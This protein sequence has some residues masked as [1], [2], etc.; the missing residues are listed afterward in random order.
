MKKLF[1]IIFSTIVLPLSAQK[2]KPKKEVDPLAGIEKELNQILKD[3]K[4]A[5]FAVAV[6][7]KDSVIYAQGFGYRDYENKLPVTPNTLFAIGS[8]TKAFTT[9]L[10][11]LMKEEDKLEYDK[12][13]K[14]Y[15][16]DLKFYS[17]DLTRNVTVRDAIVH[18]TGLPRHDF[19]WYLFSTDSREELMKRITYMEPTAP[20]RQ[21]WQYNNF[22]YLLQGMIAEKQYGK[23]WEEVVREKLLL[24]LNMKRSNTSISSYSEDKDAAIGYVLKNDS[25][26]TKT[27]Y[28]NINAMGPAGS[29]NSSVLEMAN[30]LKVW[31]NK[32]KFNG[33][34]VLPEAYI[35]EAI[36]SQ[37][38]VSPGFPGAASPDLHMSNYGF[39]WSLSSYR[40]HYRVDHG[41]NIDGFSANTAFYPS[42]SLG[43]VVLTNQN[44][45]ALNNVVR[46]TLADRLLGLK[47]IDW[48]ERI[49][50]A[51]AESKSGVTGE[52]NQKKGTQPSHPLKDYEGLYTNKGYGTFEVKYQNDSLI[53]IFPI[54][55]MWLRHYHYDV[56]QAVG[57]RKDGRVDTTEVSSVLVPFYMSEVGDIVSAKLKF[58]PELEAF[59]FDRKVKPKELSKE[60]LF[61]FEGE[62]EM[63]PGAIAKV[64]VKNDQLHVF[65]K[66]QPEYE[67]LP[68]GHQEFEIKTLKGFTLA[69][70]GKEAIESVKFIQPNGIFKALK[71]K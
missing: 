44:A 70:D 14:E 26:I 51:Q 41:G 2:N 30:W 29:I 42:D 45:S 58:Q 66:G 71:V 4:A 65:I 32:G 18:R 11:G 56:F 3:R 7:K 8:C 67:L 54:E 68:I 6:V 27:D 48:N 39:G 21:T 43:I 52:E 55:K 59:T 10:L 9:S 16:P 60:D 1:V 49:N 12:P 50:K 25:L 63:A 31:I 20:L 69:F 64:Y 28:Y 57:Y 23:T 47:G 13:I 34:V 33:K 5:G 40:G 19:S 35:R 62:Y 53:A 37:M 22:M 38:V 61:K 15:L 17:D 24:P 36:S 46:N